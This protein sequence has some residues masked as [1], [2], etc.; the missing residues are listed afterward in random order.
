ME[1]AADTSPELVMEGDAAS[2]KASGEI[3]DQLKNLNVDDIDLGF[4]ERPAAPVS[5]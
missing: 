3:D 2:T 4:E 1:A 5:D